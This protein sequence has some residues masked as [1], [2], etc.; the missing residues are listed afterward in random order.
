MS[1][2]QQQVSNKQETHDHVVAPVVRVR[3]QYFVGKDPSSEL[4]EDSTTLEVRKFVTEPAKV[5]ISKG[6]TLN[7]GNFESARLDVDF[8]VPCYLEEADSAY[9]YADKWVEN[10]LGVEVKNVRKNK[11]AIF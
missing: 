5:R 6:L 2:K 8:T 9:T 11:P 1:T 4:Y 7:L 3:R 10:K